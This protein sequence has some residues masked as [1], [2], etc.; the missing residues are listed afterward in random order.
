MKL[1]L[2]LICLLSFLS[3]FC[4]PM[5]N[6]PGSDL[7]AKDIAAV[8]TEVEQKMGTVRTLSADFTQKKKMAMFNAPVVI[9]GHIHI[10]DPDRFAWVVK[11]PVAY[12]LII[13]GDTV[14]KW[15]AVN[16]TQSLSLNDNPMFREVVDQITFWFS[17]NYAA[18]T[19][20]YD[21]SILQESPLEL[22]FVPKAHNPASQVLSKIILVFQQDLTYLHRIVLHEKKS[23]VTELAFSNIK[24]NTPQ[25]P[26]VWDE[27]Q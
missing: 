19:K 22:A 1:S 10:A 14:K 21:A 23:D 3:V 7:A 13:S 5:L 25:D 18:C 8:L 9:S 11:N 15:D 16:G 20:D 26:S 17:G 24:I 12:S 2:K 4:Y 27:K 6:L